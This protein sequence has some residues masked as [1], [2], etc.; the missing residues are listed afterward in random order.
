MMTDKTITVT[1]AEC[2]AEEIGVNAMTRHILT[3]HPEYNRKEAQ[4][5]AEVWTES[6]HEEHEQ[7]LKEYD[8]VRRLE[9]A[10][11]A[12]AFPNK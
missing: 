1:C 8:E 6:A 12:D 4:Y 7:F 11:H 3:S 5:Y 2:D 10:I 9:K